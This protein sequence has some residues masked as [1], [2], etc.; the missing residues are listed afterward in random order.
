MSAP[1][2]A[3][4]DQE[5][6]RQWTATCQVFQDEQYNAVQSLFWGQTRQKRSAPTP[7][8]SNLTTPQESGAVDQAAMEVERE[9][10]ENKPALVTFLQPFSL[11]DEAALSST[12]AELGINVADHNAVQQWLNQPVGSNRDVFAVIRAYRQK[13]IRPEF[14]SLAAHIFNIRQEL[15]WMTAENRQQRKAH[16]GRAVADNWLAIRHG[17]QRS[18]VHDRM[19]ADDDPEGSRVLW[20]GA[21]SPT[22]TPTRSRDT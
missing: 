7:C 1:S 13:V 6:D 2:R 5:A 21:A 17:P 16:S 11:Q 4:T 14:Y 9:I 10:E 18:R 12:A 20:R 22:K 3:V 15:S 8:Q 19:D